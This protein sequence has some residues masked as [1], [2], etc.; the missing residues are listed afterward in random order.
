MV[1]KSKK[2]VPSGRLVPMYLTDDGDLYP[3]YFTSMEQLELCSEMIG[4][5]LERKVVVDNK[6]LI[7]KPD[8][9]LSIYNIKSGKKEN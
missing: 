4:L 2:G 9:K 5:A 6:T 8:E 1:S 3:I 7:N